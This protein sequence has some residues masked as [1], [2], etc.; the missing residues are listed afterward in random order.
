M[1][2]V[3][4]IIVI[5]AGQMGG[6]IAQVAAQTGLDVVLNDITSELAEHGL[7]AIAKSL[8]R[9]V[10]KSRITEQE[11]AA[12]LGRITLSTSLDDAKDVDLAIEAAVERM[13][14][15]AKIFQDLDRIAPADAIL[16][17]NTSSLPIT[18][19][20]A[21]T[22]RPDK[23]IGMHFMNPVPVMELVEIIRGLQ[24]ADDTF[25]AVSEL[26]TRMGKTGIEVNDSPGF[27]V[28]RILI[29]MINEAASC[30]Q[31]G[32]ATPEG[33]DQVMKLGANHPMGPL[34]LADMIGLDTCLAIMEVLYKGFGDS[35][36]RPCPLLR[37]YVMAGWLGKKSG[38]GFYSYDR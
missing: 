4:K 18:E 2:P 27:V 12:V 26:V 23:V 25:E 13:D 31:E 6:G 21:V 3:K 7:A 10:T 30:V 33:I 28:N 34:A 17:S 15:K 8:D 29:P 35:K 32:V 37:K 16:A 36:Y 22:K 38:R 14:I 1:K 20:A 9:S 19:I 5:G 24:T 11:R